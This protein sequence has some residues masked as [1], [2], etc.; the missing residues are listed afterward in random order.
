MFYCKRCVQ[1][2]TKPDMFFSKE[3]ICGACLWIETKEQINWAEREQELRD[4]AL[5]AKS[6]GSS[7]YHCVVG[8]SGGKDSTVQAIYARDTLGL[9]PLLVS[10][11]PYANTEIG[12]ANIENL[13]QLGF[14]VVS[15]RV[16]HKV[17]LKLQ[18]QDFFSC[19]NPNRAL[20]YPLH[21]SAYIIAD[22]FDIPLVIHGDN[23]A[24]TVGTS[25]ASGLKLDGDALN[26]WKMNTI[27][28]DPLELY[29]SDDITPDDLFL[30]HVD[31][32]RLRNKGLRGVWLSNYLKEWSGHRNADFAR[33]YGL[34]SRE[35]NIDP[36]IAGTYHLSNCLDHP[37]IEVNQFLKYVKFGFGSATESAAYDIRHGFLSRPEAIAVVK[38][39]DGYLSPFAVT[40]FCKLIYIPEN[41]F[42]KHVDTFRGPMWRQLR[43]GKWHL[44]NPIWEQEEAVRDINLQELRERRYFL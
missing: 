22:K 1:P 18:R 31:V 24:Q 12:R 27:K 11:E 33:K 15:I 43:D 7:A 14:D 2:E 20:E 16:N 25:K 37:Y 8:V 34:R 26:A 28:N 32:D 40:D 21:A 29:C 35:K 42:W 5:W 36:F 19:L 38:L 13:K 10:S 17:M 3:G 6:V 39:L 30:F 9:R 4:I 41:I 23:P 44:D